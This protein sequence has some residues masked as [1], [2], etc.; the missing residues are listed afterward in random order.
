MRR[1]RVKFILLLVIAC[2]YLMQAVHEAGH[3][4]AALATGAQIHQVSIPLLGFSYT[5]VSLARQP[6]LV[7]WG[8]PIFGALAPLSLLILTRHARS[9]QSAQFFAGFCLLSNGI[10]IGIGSFTGI[11]DCGVLLDYG[12][13]LWQ[14]QLFGVITTIGGFYLWHQMGPMAQWFRHVGS[15][16]DDCSS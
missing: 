1:H 4:L 9:R 5:S 10:Y 13:A 15:N 12:A 11:G 3:C 2:W 16:P 8:G 6:L 7:I 14:L